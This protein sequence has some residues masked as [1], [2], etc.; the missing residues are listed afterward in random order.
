MLAQIRLPLKYEAEDNS[1]GLTALAGLPVFLELMATLGVP[2]EV[3]E[4]VGLRK[5]QGWSDIQ[6]VAT[7]VLLKLAGGQF[8]TD[9]EKLEC[10]DGL[11]AIVEAF[12]AHHLCETT[13]QKLAGRIRR[14]GDRTFPAPSTIREYLE[15]FE[16]EE[17]TIKAAGEEGAELPEPTDALEGLRE[18]VAR[19]VQYGEL[20]SHQETT[21][22]LDCDAT[23]GETANRSAKPCYE[24]YLA[25]Q[26]VNVF[27]YEVEQVLFSEFRDGNCPASWRIDEIV[28]QAL[29]KL[30]EYVDEVRMRSDTAGYNT[31]LIRS[32]ADGDDD[33]FGEIEFAIGVPVEEAFKQSCLECEESRWERLVREGEDEI[34][35]EGKLEYAEIP[36]VP[37]WLGHT[38]RDLGIRFLALR[39]PLGQKTLP[40]FDE[41]DARQ[42]ALP[43]PTM[44]FEADGY[45]LTGIVTNC[46]ASNA[47]TIAWYFERCGLSEQAHGECKVDLGGMPF[48]SADDFQAN[49]AWWQI[50]LLAFNLA[51]LLQR[52]FWRSRTGPLGRMKRLR[53]ELICVPGRVVTH[54]RQRTVKLPE[55]HP[56]LAR[57]RELRDMIG[58]LQR[59]PPTPWLKSAA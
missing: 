36:H 16:P 18:L 22:T 12:E 30:P 5:Q 55:D 51:K 27:W 53:F 42:E 46:E 32:M 35:T 6:Q 33:R 48:P 14:G 49:A 25:Y 7:L 50:T 10:D 43:F 13:R 41:E 24:G 40:G 20:R 54:A 58:N 38:K 34:R 4:Q 59:G 52:D 56:A 29:E 11:C 23:L 21:A 2:E 19:P 57:I 45:K 39:E 3:M 9:V 31:E 1:T 17:A 15:A 8:I 26:P 44:E 28:E 47:E 37:N